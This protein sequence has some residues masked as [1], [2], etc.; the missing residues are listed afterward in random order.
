[1]KKNE[2]QQKSY[3]VNFPE[4]TF[5]GDL[6]FCTVYAQS[7]RYME[8]MDKQNYFYYFANNSKNLDL[9]KWAL[10]RN[11]VMVKKH[12]SKYMSTYSK[13]PCL[14]VLT[15][16]LEKSQHGKDFVACLIKSKDEVDNGYTNHVD[17]F[18]SS[19]YA[20]TL[21]LK[22]RFGWLGYLFDKTKMK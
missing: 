12:D 3:Y 10:R 17:G 13:I 8:S 6:N 19:M 9:V 20:G 16:D 22:Y 4:L 5:E 1:M 14:R 18:N 2:L 15:R 21:Q 7:A 11:G